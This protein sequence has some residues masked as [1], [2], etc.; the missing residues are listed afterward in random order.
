MNYVNS[1]KVLAAKFRG[2]QFFKVWSF[3]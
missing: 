3:I 2:E 1:A